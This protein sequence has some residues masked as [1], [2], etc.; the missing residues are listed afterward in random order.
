MNPK[1]VTAL[2]IVVPVA[3]LAAGGIG[4]A[5]LA[6]IRPDV[7][8]RPAEVLAPQIRVLRVEPQ[9]IRLSVR[10]Q[11]TVSPRSES[12]V[13]PEISGRVVWVSPDFISGGFFEDGQ[14]LLRIESYDYEQAVVRA[15]AQVAATKLRLALEE[16][17]AELAAEEWAELGEGEAPPLT[18]RVPQLAN[19]RA[20]VAAAEANLQQADHNLRRTEI[21]APYAGRVRD[22]SVDIGQFVSPGA[23]LG[24]LYAIDYAEIRLP[25]PDGDLAYVDLP[26]VYRGDR[27]RRGPRVTLSAEFARRTWTWSGRVV[28]T[29][30]E[31]DR[32]SRMV[33]AVAQVADP[34]G[35]GADPDR[36][37]LAAG[38][39]VRAEIAG[40]TMHDVVVLPRA[41]VR[42]D[43][44]ILVVD[45]DNRLRFREIEVAR[46]DREQVI[47]S[48]GLGSGDRVCLTNLDVV[49]DGMPVRVA[50]PTTGSDTMT[51]AIQ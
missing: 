28:R 32:A 44:R 15:Q 41:A 30:G 20:A 3:I 8:T 43:G 26:L 14:P 6:T 36:P 12:R 7:E 45:A 24:V 11:G 49:T 10:S 42:A 17:E 22:K 48:A 40:I 27:A 29:E 39:Y 35:R 13:V 1:L 16:A 25:L 51:E 46:A 21:R 47:V 2:K 19:A 5:Q 37:P 50:E 23:S 9:D 4:A 33:H 31:I 38:M 18:L 34:Y